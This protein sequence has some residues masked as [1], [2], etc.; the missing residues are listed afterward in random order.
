M[1]A[2][3]KELRGGQQSRKNKAQQGV[4]VSQK[5]QGEPQDVSDTPDSSVSLGTLIG[6][7]CKEEVENTPLGRKIEVSVKLEHLTGA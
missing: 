6:T 5:P 7:G 1:K 4:G 3:G 2:P